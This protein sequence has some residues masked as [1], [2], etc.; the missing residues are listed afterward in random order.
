MV[1]FNKTIGLHD[2]KAYG[3]RGI[4]NFFCCLF[5]WAIHQF[6][7]GHFEMMKQ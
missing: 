5:Y 6:E 7:G 2:A 4:L 1:I 3:I